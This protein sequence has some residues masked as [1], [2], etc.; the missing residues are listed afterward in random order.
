MIPLDFKSI[1]EARK[2]LGLDA[3]AALEEIRAA[4][5]KLAAEHHPDRHAGPDVHENDRKAAERRFQE[6]SHAHGVLAD[7]CSRYRFSFK[8][9]DVRRMAVDPATREHL[10]RYY[11]GLWGHSV[12]L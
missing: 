5:K 4:Y 10:K 1:D 11:D 12:D 8:E 9:D 2:T 7:Y 3:Y 6:I